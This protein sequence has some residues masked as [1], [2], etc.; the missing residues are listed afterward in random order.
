MFQIHD[1][2]M[3]NVKSIQLITIFLDQEVFVTSVAMFVLRNNRKIKIKRFL[4][5]NS[6]LLVFAILQ[7][8]WTD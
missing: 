5:S 4:V 7:T 2:Q 1:H 6:C 3:S 8:D